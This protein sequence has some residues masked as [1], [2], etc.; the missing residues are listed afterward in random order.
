VEPG[1]AKP[2]AAAPKVVKSQFETIGAAP[3]GAKKENAPQNGSSSDLVILDKPR[4]AY[5]EEARHLQIEGSVLLE[6]SFG[7]SGQVRVLRVVRGLGHGLDEIAI[8]AAGAIHF[9]PAVEHGLPVDSMATVKIEFR[10]AY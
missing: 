3:A 2:A 10:L 1:P 4:P 7:A 9:Q 6:A 8:K 5:S